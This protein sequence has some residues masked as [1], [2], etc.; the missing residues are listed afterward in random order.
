MS[1]FY[2]LKADKPDGSKLDFSELKGKVVLI[3]NVASQ[4]G[5]TKQY[6]GLQALYNKYKEK[7]FVILGF[8]CNQFGG[9]EKGSDDEIAE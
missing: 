1:K 7:D 8:P 3:V 4:C 5:F 2:E 9:Q 6:S